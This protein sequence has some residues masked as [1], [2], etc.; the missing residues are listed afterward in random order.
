MKYYCTQIFFFYY[1]LEGI[2]CER[3]FISKVIIMH[4][5]EFKQIVVLVHFAQSYQTET[6]SAFGGWKCNFR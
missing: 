3:I 4:Y 6:E 2:D 1:K 5:K